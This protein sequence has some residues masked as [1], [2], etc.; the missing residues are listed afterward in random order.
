[1]RERKRGRDRETERQ[2]DRGERR[3][4]EEQGVGGLLS[5]AMSANLPVRKKECV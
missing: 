4:A 1:V 5:A 2:R 3:E